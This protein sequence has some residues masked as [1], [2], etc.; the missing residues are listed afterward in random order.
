MAISILRQR[1]HVIK[2]LWAN[3]KT[4]APSFSLCRNVTN[5]VQRIAELTRVRGEPVWTL[6]T[7][8]PPAV[9]PEGDIH[10]LL[11]CCHTGGDAFLFLFFCCFFLRPGAHMDYN[12]KFSLLREKELCQQSSPIFL[13]GGGGG[14]GHEE[15]VG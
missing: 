5:S 10:C 14:G 9:W 12:I 11:V 7:N 3:L 4:P 2:F 8:G 15:C 1:N 13:A 6:R